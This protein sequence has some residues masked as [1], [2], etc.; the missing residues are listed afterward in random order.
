MAD[1]ENKCAHPG[2]NCPALPD[3]KYCSPHCETAPDEVI[4]GCGH[5]GCQS[6]TVGG[7]TQTA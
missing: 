4:C 5:Q 1:N 6:S 7:R 2:C 3:E